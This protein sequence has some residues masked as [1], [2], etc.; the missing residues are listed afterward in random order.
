[1]GLT[2]KELN[3]NIKNQNLNQVKDCIPGWKHSGI[4]SDA[5]SEQDV[6]RRISCAC[7]VMQNLSSDVWISKEKC[8]DG[9][10]DQSV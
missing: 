9:N 10:K 3:I 2:D 7:G 4:Q 1:V 5:S 6:K 8:V